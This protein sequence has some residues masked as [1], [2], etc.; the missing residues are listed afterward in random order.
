MLWNV[1]GQLAI[2]TISGRN[3]LFNVGR[4]VTDIGE[5]VVKDPELDQYKEGKYDGEF[6]IS[7]ISPSYYS[8][9]GRLVVEVRAL[10]GGMTLSEVDTLSSDDAS[11]ITTHDVDPAD[12]ETMVVNKAT[13]HSKKAK[14]DADA[15]SSDKAQAS[16]NQDVPT[17]PVLQDD[18][19]LFGLLWEDIKAFNTFKL[20][21]TVDRL[22]FRKQVKRLNDLGFDFDSDKQEWCFP[23][24]VV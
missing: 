1:P 19:T 8:T 4:L 23:E 21:P 10:L 2:R 5:F 18:E 17:A 6:T 14:D 15:V 24:A 3:G 9:N 22:T 13:S 20:D 11:Q 16:S 7:K 12:E